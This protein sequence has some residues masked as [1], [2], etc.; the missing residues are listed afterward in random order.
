[1]IDQP[2]FYL[3]GVIAVL[4]AG[5]SKGG[6]G[7]GLGVIAVP[8]MS[9]VIPPFQAAAIMLPILCV[10]DLAGLKAYWR[11]WHVQNLKIMLPGALIGI[12]LA[13]ITYHWINENAL[14]IMIGAIAVGFALNFYLN[15]RARLANPK[16]AHWGR[17]AFW[18]AIAGF[19]SFS[20]HA[21]GPPA[22]IYLLP[23]RLDK[24]LFVGTTVVLFT[25]VNYVKLVPYTLMGQFQTQNLLSSLIL[26][27]AALVGVYLGVYLHTRVPLNLFYRICYFFLLLTG[28]RLLQQ[29]LFPT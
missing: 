6:F 9:L 24:T 26:A 12:L 27:P 5:I 18:S 1:M 16:T 29:G 15:H 10:M 14:R 21:G 11:R 7:G 25:A 22:A 28:L 4:I 20:A 3:A 23:Q 17:G 13:V 19:T 2:L 8:L